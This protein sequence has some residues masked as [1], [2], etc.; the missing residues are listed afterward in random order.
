[1]TGI[2]WVLQSRTVQLDVD[3]VTFSLFHSFLNS[4]WNFTGFTATETNT[5]IAITNNSQCSKG[6][7]TTTFNNLGYT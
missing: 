7:N 5:A 3:H 6:E 4:G 2:H 1:M